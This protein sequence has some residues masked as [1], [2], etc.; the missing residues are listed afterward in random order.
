MS[1]SAGPATGWTTDEVARRVAADLRMGEVVNLGIG[2]PALVANHV[3][4]ALGI[5]LHSEN[6]IIGMGPQASPEAADPDLID[7]GKT[8]TTLVAGAAIVGHGESF[9]VIRG[10]HL[11]CAVLGALQVSATGDLANWRVPTSRLGSVGGA[12]DIAVGAR[13]VI[14]M[15]RHVDKAGTPKIVDRCTYP[16][17]APRCVTVIATDLALIDVEPDGLVVREAAVDRDTLQR[18]TGAALRWRDDS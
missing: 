17:T 12:M 9:G 16:L 8:P 15:M 1:G 11:D 5:I 3:D 18:L 2:L 14:A 7:A 6:G 10:G 4:P 13:R